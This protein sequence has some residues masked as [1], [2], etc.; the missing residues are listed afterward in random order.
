MGDVEMN[1]GQENW[2]R[3]IRSRYHPRNRW[4]T[5]GG[6]TKTLNQRAAGM[7][8]VVTNDTLNLLMP[9]SSLRRKCGRLSSLVGQGAVLR[10]WDELGRH[11]GSSA[12]GRNEHLGRSAEGL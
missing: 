11:C 4:L 1:V 3:S 10:Q 7:I 9:K 6:S 5:L 8:E 2:T 12:L